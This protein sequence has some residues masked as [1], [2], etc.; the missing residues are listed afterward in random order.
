MNPILQGRHSMLTCHKADCPSCNRS[1]RRGGEATTTR[2]HISVELKA[3]P[4]GAR[5]IKSLF[6]G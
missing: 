5:K 1:R 3:T 4:G 2:A 6:G